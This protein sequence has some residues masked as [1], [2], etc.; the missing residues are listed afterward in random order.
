MKKFNIVIKDLETGET[1]V[2]DV[3]SA[4][5]G[6]FEAGERG[7]AAIAFVS[8]KGKELLTTLR[9]AEDVIEKIYVE[10]PELL[11]NGKIAEL[12]DIMKAVEEG[13]ETE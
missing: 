10:H 12:L 13:G 9:G 4:I 2:D 5:V 6:S 3:T 11:I 8:C 7:A 1:L